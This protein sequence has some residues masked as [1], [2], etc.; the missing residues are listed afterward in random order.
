MKFVPVI[1]LKR[2]LKINDQAPRLIF[3]MTTQ[4]STKLIMLINVKMLTLVDILTFISIINISLNS[5][6]AR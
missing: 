3:F 1:F 2:Q 5:L 6:K 4:L